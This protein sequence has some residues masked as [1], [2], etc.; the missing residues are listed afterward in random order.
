M[1]TTT[2]QMR[3]ETTTNNNKETTKLMTYE[4]TTTSINNKT[5]DNDYLILKMTNNDFEEAHEFLLNDFLEGEPLNAALGVN[6]A[7]ALDF[8]AGK[9]FNIGLKIKYE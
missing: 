8:F 3:P 1:S 7:E 2:V 5:I 6:R 9:L 4:P